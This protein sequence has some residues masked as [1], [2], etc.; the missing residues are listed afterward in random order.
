MKWATRAAWL[1]RRFAD[2]DAVFVFADDPDE[3]PAD[4]TPFDMRGADGRAAGLT[5]RAAIKGQSRGHGPGAL[6]PHPTMRSPIGPRMSMG[7]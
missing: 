6:V 7:K 2:A 3:V 4:A 1:I 5:G